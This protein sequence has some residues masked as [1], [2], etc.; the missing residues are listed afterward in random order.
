MVRLT[1]KFRAEKKIAHSYET[2]NI[3]NQF[4]KKAFFIILLICVTKQI[5]AQTNNES[6]E[7]LINN[8]KPWD[9]GYTGCFGPVITDSVMSVLIDKGK[10][11][12]GQ[13]L[14]YLDEPEKAVSVHVI[15]S[16]IYG[17]SIHSQE[18]T[19][20][21]TENPVVKK[22][23]INGLILITSRSPGKFTHSIDKKSQQETI[24]MWRLRVN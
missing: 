21:K 15:L 14:R 23:T 5:A 13:L 17:D 10:P 6:I 16:K 8:L 18:E 12:A 2:P 20:S 9:N 4:M 7:T 19:V 22:R 11:I 24:A 1:E 3:I